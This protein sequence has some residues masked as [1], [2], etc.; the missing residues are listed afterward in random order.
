MRELI[1]G[2]S[3]AI[4]FFLPPFAVKDVPPFVVWTGVIGGV[5]ICALAVVPI[6]DKFLFPISFLVAG[7]L[8]VIA[9]GMVLY[10]RFIQKQEIGV[11][12]E[13][14]AALEEKLPGVSFH[15]A[16][17]ID[18]VTALRRKYIFELKSP[19]GPA[20]AFFLSASNLFTFAVSDTRGESYSIQ[21]PIGKDGI[22][23]GRFIHLVCEGGSSSNSSFLRIL[24]DGKQ[25]QRR[26]FPLPI[27]MGNRL[28]QLTIGADSEK[29]NNAT[30]ALAEVIFYTMTFNEDEHRKTSEYFKVQ[31]MPGLGK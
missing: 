3:L 30:F 16:L 11:P 18:N 22:P 14:S 21:L 19:D 2:S 1:F 28:W 29:K 15:A 13:Q 24:V 4:V 23:M 25:I 7:C 6:D 31:V 5:F 8:I 9:S 12:K 27:D 20:A 10:E 26:D 17:R